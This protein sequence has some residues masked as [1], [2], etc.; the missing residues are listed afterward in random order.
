MEKEAR[1]VNHKTESKPDSSHDTVTVQ[2]PPKSE[3]DKDKVESPT[4]AVSV[5]DHIGVSAIDLDVAASVEKEADAAKADKISKQ[6]G[7][8]GEK[9][10]QVELQEIR[11]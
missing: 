1:Q 9:E 7:E 8:S 11:G 5:L 4:A 2:Q 3:R 6:S 10:K